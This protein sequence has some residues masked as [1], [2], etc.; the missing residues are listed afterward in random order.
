MPPSNGEDVLQLQL[1]SLSKCWASL[2]MVL[3]ALALFRRLQT[4]VE[5][6]GW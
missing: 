2:A 5:E 6:E 3:A 1:H 4:I